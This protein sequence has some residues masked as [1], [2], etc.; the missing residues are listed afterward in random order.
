MDSDVKCA[1]FIDVKVAPQKE[2]ALATTAE[3]LAN[4][5]SIDGK[6]LYTSFVNR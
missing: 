3:L 4:Q 5:W 1:A 2:A 6:E